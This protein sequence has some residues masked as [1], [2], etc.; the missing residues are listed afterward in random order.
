MNEIYPTKYSISALTVF[1]IYNGS[2][3]WF[4]LSKKPIER[5]SFTFGDANYADGGY[6]ITEKCIGCGKCLSAC[7]QRC[8]DISDG[9][10]VTR[11]RNCLRCG[12]CMVDCPNG[13]VKMR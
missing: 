8:I 3:E 11:Q 13:A 4:D 9:H 5:E 6:Y 2:G 1:M 7:P 12:N 10:A